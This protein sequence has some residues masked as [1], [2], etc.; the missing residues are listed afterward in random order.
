MPTHTLQ[1]DPD[2]SQLRLDVY[3][4]RSLT[5]VP[6]RS[7]IKKLIEAGHVKVNGKAV[8]A[9]Y[10]VLE[11]D[12]LNIEIPKDFLAQGDITAEDIPLDVFYEDQHLIIIN[13]PIGMVVH[14]A[15]GNR[16]G[17]L[18]NALMNYSEELSD[19]NSS[20]R[21]GIVHRLDQDTSGLIVIA[22]D[23]IAHARLARQFQRHEV[24]KRYIAL[25]E[26]EIEFD[27]GKIDAPLSRDRR[28]FEKRAVSS[29]ENDRGAREAVTYYEVIKRHKG[30]TLVALY[31][32][33]GRTH[34][35]RVHMAHLRHPILGDVKYGK[36]MTFPRLALHAQAISFIHPMT[37]ATIGFSLRPPQEFLT[38]VGLG[39]VNQP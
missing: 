3:L 35:L 26:G 11:G 21:P 34:Q 31:P 4:T 18:V 1:V 5:D 30:I 27:Q 12:K 22:K 19:N 38:K 2:S 16:T 39:S 15:K 29:V 33:T 23:N 24:R 37:K 32:R 25:V 28:N 17:T 9:H 13:K 8:K 36:K 6:S 20:M 7:F 14:P 10:K